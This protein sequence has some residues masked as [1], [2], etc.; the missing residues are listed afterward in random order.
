LKTGLTPR[1]LLEQRDKS[2]KTVMDMNPP[3]TF[4]RNETFLGDVGYPWL[5]LCIYHP[6]HKAL[7]VAEL[8]VDLLDGEWQDL[9]FQTETLPISDLK[10]WLPL[11]K[12]TKEKDNAPA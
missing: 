6:A 3:E 8:Q 9:Y 11:P 2:I 5:A 12:I 4:P 10:G 7:A 1:Q